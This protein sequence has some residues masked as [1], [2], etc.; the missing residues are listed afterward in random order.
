MFSGKK[1]SGAWNFGPNINN[2]LKVLELVNYCKKTLS[3]KSKIMIKKSN[4]MSQLI[5]RLIAK[6][7]QNT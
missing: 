5:S 2:N 6:N 3:S 1:F 7:L 4:Y